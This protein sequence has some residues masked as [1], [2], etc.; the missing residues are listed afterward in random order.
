MT[1]GWDD[2]VAAALVGAGRA[3]VP[4]TAEGGALGEALA[5]A[6]DL[7]GMATVLSA[8]REAGWAVAADEAAAPEPAPDDSR[9]LPSSRAVATLRTILS[10]RSLAALL[11]EWLG[12]ASAA[13]LRLPAELVPEVFEAVAGGDRPAGAA[14]A[15]PVGAW[16]ARRNEA[17]S[18]ALHIPSGTGAGWDELERRWS[19]G[20]DERR[21]VAL[22]GLR[23]LDADRARGLLETTW[24]HEP[25]A[26]RVWALDLLAESLTPGDEPLLE[27]ALDDR[28]KDVRRR[29]AGLLARLP[30]SRRAAR[31]AAR[32][33][34]CVRVE[35]W[36]RRR[37]VVDR[38]AEVD[39]AARD[40]IERGK[41]FR[42]LV[43]GSPLA[44]W[45]VSL[46]RPPT[47]LVE[48]AQSA[49]AGELLAGWAEAAAAQQDRDWARALCRAGAV[50]EGWPALLAVLPEAERGAVAEER[51]AR[52]GLRASMGLLVSGP[53]WPASV[54]GAVAGALA[55]LAARKPDADAVAVGANLR[56]LALC[57][58]P[59]TAP[60]VAARVAGALAALP[61]DEA[62]AARAVW[63]RPLAAFASLAH[64]RHLLT[65]EL[66]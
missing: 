41:E 49:G 27:A 34:P 43:A 64:V 24:V 1:T 19:E 39:T 66:R 18:W 54:S 62:A 21:R 16:L 25:A 26:V 13:G 14:L 36:P 60:A 15:G 59:A 17:W 45:V 7:L 58:D 32:A 4:A 44:A 65:E 11:P 42:Q 35:G 46:G 8:Y 29:A 12:R 63:E 51:I 30:E 40:G 22:A 3:A 61:P 48:L 55:A 56:A 31:L 23:R 10:D 53:S 5:Q 52:H 28:R 2:L 37:L 47:E 57:L 38:P 9:P 6:G 20:S 50:P 33:V